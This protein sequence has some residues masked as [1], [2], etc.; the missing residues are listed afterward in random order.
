MSETDLKTTV[1][2][3]INIQYISSVIGKGIDMSEKNNKD[4]ALTALEIIVDGAASS[5]ATPKTRRAAA[6][7]ASLVL[8][9]LKGSLDA[10]KTKAILSIIEMACEVESTA[11]ISK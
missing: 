9:D 4:T 11:F 3:C 7:L 2:T 1:E 5:E 6:Y 10:Q 8:A